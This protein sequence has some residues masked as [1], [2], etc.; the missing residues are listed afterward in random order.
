M[1]KQRKLIKP[2]PAEDR[3]IKAGIAADP[4]TYELSAAEFRKLRPL[5][6]LEGS[7]SKAPARYEHR[8]PGVVITRARAA[9]YKRVAIARGKKAAKPTA[10]PAG[11]AASTRRPSRPSARRPR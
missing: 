11:L 4:D 7:S 6:E 8:V 10:S 3:A 5:G 2:T 9:A 1:K